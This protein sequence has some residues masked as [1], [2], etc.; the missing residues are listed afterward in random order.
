VDAPGSIDRYQIA[1]L[2][3]ISHCSQ[4]SLEYLRKEAYR[5]NLQ[6]K[7]YEKAKTT[8]NGITETVEKRDLELIIR[9]AV[10]ILLDKK[11]SL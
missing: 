1:W 11:A 2:L 4:L 9:K 5:N 6:G 3:A 10:D 7:L 8:D